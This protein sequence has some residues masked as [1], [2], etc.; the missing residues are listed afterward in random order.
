M[1]QINYFCP[2][3]GSDH[4]PAPEFLE[5]VKQAGYDGVEMSIPLDE[6]ER[7]GWLDL[8]REYNLQWVAQHYETLSSDFEEHKVLYRK[9]L[10]NLAS[11]GPVFINSQTG[12][13]YFSFEQNAE[14]LAIARE[15]SQKYAVKI[16]HET[17][18]G[19]FSFAAHV[20]RQYLERIPDLL[21]TVDFSHWCSVAESMLEDQ[22][23]AME[24]AMER[25]YHIH[26]RV[27]FPEGPQIPDPRAPEWQSVLQAH[28]YWWQRIIGL[29]KKNGMEK[30]TITTE[31][32]P[33][34]YMTL[35]PHTTKPIAS[36]WDV[37]VFMM[38]FLKENLN[39]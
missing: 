22:A 29:R 9:Y 4:L 14:L 1:M 17:H 7:N 12:K 8:F 27:G 2:L 31:F 23:E 15:I 16:Y 25:A 37:N 30:L 3:W 38:N 5:K 11:S 19:K 36:Q 13:D 20:T 26:A 21:L 32:G 24:L 28:L 39:H 33:Y 34:P 6:K 10:E 18:R 35:L